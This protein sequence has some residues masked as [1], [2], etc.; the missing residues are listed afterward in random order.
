MLGLS[1]LYGKLIA[2]LYQKYM[3]KANKKKMNEQQKKQQAFYKELKA[4]YNFVD[5]LNKK[6]L[7]N[8][9]QRKTFWKSVQSNKPVIEG[10]L[11]DLITQYAPK[12]K[13]M[14]SHKP[15]ELQEG[16]VV[17]GGVNKAPTTP[18]PEAPKGQGGKL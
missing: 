15:V 13:D 8:R 17:K 9:Q 5:W 1:K 6:G 7:K 11:Q 3:T 2:K 12:K 14:I 18:R 10:V 4:L 16:K